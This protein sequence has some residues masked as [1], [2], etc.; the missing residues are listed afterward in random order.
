MSRR[1]QITF[2]GTSAGAP[3]RKRGLPA[4]LVSDGFRNILLDCGEGTQY[5]LQSVGVSVHSID[6][7]LITHLHG[8]HVFGLPGLIASM[9]LLGRIRDLRIVGPSGIREYLEANIK[10]LSTLPFRI[11]IVEVDPPEEPV[12]IHREDNFEVQCVATR[13]SVKS[14][15]YALIWRV[16]VGKFNPE[17]AK[18]LNIPVKYWKKLQ[19]GETVI[20]E[21]GRTIRPE[22]VVEV[23]HRGYI[24]IVYTGDTAPTDTIIKLAHGADILIHE[25]T[26]SA[27]EDPYTIWRQGHSRTVDAA[28]IAKKANVQTL[29]LTHISTRYEDQEHKLLQEAKTIFPNTYLA[30][31][32]EKYYINVEFD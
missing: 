5:K 8:D 13:H 24:K 22:E 15:A 20:L 18:M 2:L 4:V 1:I 12:T 27:D 26:F 3:S 14:C 7:I 11:H 6:L 31:D 21:D 25:A 16:P 29:I 23:K 10:F 32:L 28:E 19:F 9:T 17:K 30:N